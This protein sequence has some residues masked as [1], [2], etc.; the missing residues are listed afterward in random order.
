MKR[1]LSLVAAVLMLLVGLAALFAPNAQAAAALPGVPD[2]KSA[3]VAQMPGT[4]VPGFLDPAPTPTPP[5]GDPFAKAHT[6]SVYEQYGYAGLTWN[7]YDLGC[8]PDPGTNIDTMLGNWGLDFATATVAAANGLHNKIAHPDFLAPLDLIVA[9]VTAAI[10]DA[11]WTPWGAVALLVVVVGLLRHS[12]TGSLS[13]VTKGAAWSVFVIVLLAGV[14]QYPAR[15]SAFFD[16]SVTSTI[17]SVDAV[18]AGLSKIPSGADPARAQGALLVDRMLYDAWLRGQFGQPDS[19][20]AKAY[21]PRLFKDSAYTW[22]EAAQ[23]ESD[24][25]KEQSLADAKAADFKAATDEIQTKDPAGYLEIQG[26]SGNRAGVGLMTVF[27]VAFTSIFRIV[28]ELFV[29]AGLIMLRF[30]VMFFPAIAVA[31]L[32]V[33]STL[34]RVGNIAGASVVNVIAFSAGAAIQTTIV[35]ALLRS[36]PQ[37]GMSIVILALAMVTTVVAFI[38]LR[39]LLSLS[40]IVGIEASKGKQHL[41]K[42]VKFADRHAP[43]VLPAPVGA[44]VGAA[45]EHEWGEKSEPDTRPRPKPTPESFGRPAQEQ[46]EQQE[47]P[48]APTTRRDESATEQLRRV[49]GAGQDSPALFDPATKADLPERIHQPSPSAPVDV[50]STKEVRV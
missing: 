15:V 40:N 19:A 21:G 48:Q 14:T 29:F 30:L 11:I 16:D 24:P 1:Q 36:A 18:S 34:R 22:A 49:G 39:P 5:P 35:A 12:A 45:V 44:V 28:A 8:L 27:G 33:P 2:C 37:G 4:G 10:K 46:P 43:N 42:V 32:L 47:R 26:K 3:P 9:S 31:G 38:L 6:T 13:A 20:T 50:H 25:A 17:A 7:T 23:A 41:Q